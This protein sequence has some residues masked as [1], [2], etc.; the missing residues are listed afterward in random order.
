MFQ[1]SLHYW[2]QT[3]HREKT[4]TIYK[5]G[6]EPPSIFLEPAFFEPE[7]KKSFIYH[8]LESPKAFWGEKRVLPW[9]ENLWSFSLFSSDYFPWLYFVD[10]SVA[11]LYSLFY[12]TREFHR[13]LLR[14]W[15]RKKK[16]NLLGYFRFFSN[17]FYVRIAS[18]QETFR[19]LLFPPSNS[20]PA[21]F[22]LQP[23]YPKMPWLKD[24][25]FVTTFV[26]TIPTHS[27][28]VTTKRA[29]LTT[30]KWSLRF[31]SGLRGRARK[32]PP[33][34]R[35]DTGKEYRAIGTFLAGGD[36]TICR[37]L[38]NFQENWGTSRRL[39]IPH[40]RKSED[41]FTC[42]S[43]TKSRERAKRL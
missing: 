34:A 40:T 21:H 2:N 6:F 7:L 24:Y 13:F 1:C 4:H 37:F 39:S 11:S 5:F 43:T 10:F 27:R 17:L 26:Q 8:P 42:A 33:G 31:S 3:Q 38:Y 20:F 14:G 32:W 16:K 18:R 22:S 30:S 29:S 35:G 23:R 9:Y 36:L 25:I 12:A 19:H 15:A 41:K 28:A